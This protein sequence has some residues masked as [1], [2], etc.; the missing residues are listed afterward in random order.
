MMMPVPCVTI[1]PLLSAV[2]KSALVEALMGFQ[3]NSV[4]GG[5]KTRRPIAIHMKYNAS[6]ASPSCFLLAEDGAGEKAM[7]L[8]EL[9]VRE[10]GGGGDERDLILSWLKQRSTWGHLGWPHWSPYDFCLLGQAL[11]SSIGQAPLSSIGEAPLSS[12]ARISNHR[13]RHKIKA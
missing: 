12:I 7:A 5:T 1:S 10:T 2:G 13:L 3:F 6:C 11:L 9:Q 8:Q 4:G